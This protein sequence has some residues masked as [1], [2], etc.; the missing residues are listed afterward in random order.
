MNGPPWRIGQRVEFAT[1]DSDDADTR[2]LDGTAATVLA[3]D[4]DRDLVKVQSR[5]GERWH[6]PYEFI[7][8]R[9]V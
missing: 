8:A 4:A 1:F 6:D 2:E 5:Y 3:I 9:N 7:E